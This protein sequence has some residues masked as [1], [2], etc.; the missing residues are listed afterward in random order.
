MTTVS[1][2][3]LVADHE[4]SL[5]EIMKI[6]L[7]QIGY[8][9]EFAENGEEAFK[10]LN[11]EHFPIILMDLRIPDIDGVELCMQ[12]KQRNPESVIYAFSGSFTDDEF[13]QIEE[14]GFDGLLCKPVKFD[15]LKSAIKGACEKINK[16]RSGL[17]ITSLCNS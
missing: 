2:K 16:R 12:I 1:K 3:I 5:K 6:M 10:I 15:V 13:D 11:R 9:P 17:S 14:M 4:K 7:V 8:D